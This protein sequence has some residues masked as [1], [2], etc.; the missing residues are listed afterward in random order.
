MGLLAARHNAAFCWSLN[1]HV[2]GMECDEDIIHSLLP[3]PVDAQYITQYKRKSPAAIIMRLR[4][5]LENLIQRNKVEKEAQKQIYQTIS[6][7]N[8]AL[9]IAERIRNSPVPPLYTAHT[10]R[11]LIF[12]LFW[13]PLALFGTIQNG[14]N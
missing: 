1:A 7:L 4:Q 9:T 10:T 11:L 5:I 13:L 3:N 2:R 8:E 6:K 12:Y 14:S